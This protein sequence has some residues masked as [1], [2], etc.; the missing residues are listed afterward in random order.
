MTG[1]MQDVRP[2]SI[3]GI[4]KCVKRGCEKGF[5]IYFMS[6]SREFDPLVNVSRLNTRLQ[7]SVPFRIC[8]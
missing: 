3:Q 1:E 7:R 8:D 6:A 4:E 5:E 2:I